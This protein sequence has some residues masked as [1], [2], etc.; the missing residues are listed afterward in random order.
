MNESEINKTAAVA[1]PPL[2]I[3]R[4]NA[5]ASSIPRE[6]P[7]RFLLVTVDGEPIKRGQGVRGREGG[8]MGVTEGMG[9]IE[10]LLE[11]GS[12]HWANIAL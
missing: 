7:A 12:F 8:Y 6:A 11:T 5:H 1:P 3:L 4:C 10:S 9:S 2:H